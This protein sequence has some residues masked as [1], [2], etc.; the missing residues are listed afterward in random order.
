MLNN[1]ARSF[2]L[3]AFVALVSNTAPLS[4]AAVVTG[5]VLDA[6]NGAPIAGAEVHVDGKPLGLA[7][8]ENG[9][10]S[11]EVAG[12]DRLFTFKHAGF[13]EQSVGPLAVPQEGRTT[14]P[15]ARLTPVAQDSEVVM[16]DRLVLLW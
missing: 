6:T 14:A 10:F 8:D 4:A 15:D 11:A 5:R 3:A 7:T 13:S 2:G 12:G 9:R 1:Q 16:L